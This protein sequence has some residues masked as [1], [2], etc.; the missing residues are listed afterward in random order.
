M[1]QIA[2]GRVRFGCFELDPRAGELTGNGHRT[3]LQEQQLKVLLML[4]ERAGEIA[5]REEIKQK[6]WPN[7][8]I[9][10]FDFGINST[11]K[12][13]RGCLG[14][15]AQNPQYIETLAR[16]GWLCQ[17]LSD[18]TDLQRRRPGA[19]KHSRILEIDAISVRHK[20]RPA[21]AARIGSF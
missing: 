6:L 5:T 17:R 11:I 15:S 8:T 1:P 2:Q 9:V 18:H 7:D 12:K 14:D 3:L 16:R 13:L 10:E 21:Q 4:I 19:R 20:H